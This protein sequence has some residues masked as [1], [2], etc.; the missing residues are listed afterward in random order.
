VASGEEDGKGV[1]KKGGLGCFVVGME[2]GGGYIMAWEVLGGEWSGWV[3]R[4]L[5]DGLDT[6]IA[7]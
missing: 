1:L 3:E 2:E 5:T 7:V 4:R 6:W